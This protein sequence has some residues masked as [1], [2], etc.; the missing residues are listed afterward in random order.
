MRTVLVLALCAVVATAHVYFQETFSDGWENRWVKSSVK[1]AEGTAG[2]MKVTAGKWYNNAEEDKGLQTSQD[3]RFYI[4][5]APMEDWSNKDKTLV[6]QYQIKHEQKIDCGGG[7]LKLIPKD[8]FTDATKFAPDSKYNIMFGPDVCGTSTR[9]THLIFGKDGVNHLINKEIKCETDQLT[10][11]YTLIVNPDNTYEVLIDNESVQKGNL[12]DDWD[13][14]PPKEI[15]DPEANK[16]EDW[17][18]EPE[19]DDPADKKPEGWDD[20]PALIKDPSAKKPED[21]DDETD[22]EW[23]APMIDNPEYKGPWK[24]KKI[25]NPAYKGVWVHPKIANPEYKPNPNLYAYDSFAHVGIE[26]WQVKAGTIF[27]NIVVT[28][29]LEEAKTWAAKWTAMKDGEKKMFEAEE[30]KRRAQ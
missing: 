25:P 23:E 20:I 15:L 7:Y 19:M 11:L 16:P 29:S 4:V 13:M 6:L 21:W 12:E 10:H 3:A 2:E 27:D 8:A 17:V 28:D 22:G 26:I 9:K 1:D 14:V 18:D 30:E 24:A 5:S